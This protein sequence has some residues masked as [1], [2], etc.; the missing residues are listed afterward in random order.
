M[1]TESKS[2]VTRGQLI[3]VVVIL[4]INLVLWVIPGDIVEQ[5]ARDRQTLLGRYS[6][7]HFTWILAVFAV[8]A[9]LIRLHLS[10]TK[11]VKKKRIFRVVAA[12]LA[13]AVALFAADVT[14]R[15]TKSWRYVLGD[16]AYHRPPGSV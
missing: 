4:L 8:S 15:L 6:R 9:I 2:K 1:E 14:L 7:R 5:V 3:F 13:L 10:P 16:L 11:A 12:L